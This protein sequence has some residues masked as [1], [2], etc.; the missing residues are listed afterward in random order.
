MKP[1]LGQHSLYDFHGCSAHRLTDTVA[2]RL[3]L[4]E[5]VRRAGGT[6]VTE[7]FHTFSPHGVSGVVVI[8]E[9]HVTLHTWPEHA[10]AAVDVFSCGMS[11]RHQ[12]IRDELQAALGAVSVEQRIFARGTPTAPQSQR[13]S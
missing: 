5:I 13:E 8:A 10:Y 12:Q 11:L 2:L 6:I 7:A 4:L 3:A 1:P 9:S